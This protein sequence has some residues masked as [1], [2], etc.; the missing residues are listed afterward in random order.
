[1]TWRYIAQRTTTGDFLDWD[2]PFVA[3]SPRSGN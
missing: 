1:M 2:V 3:G